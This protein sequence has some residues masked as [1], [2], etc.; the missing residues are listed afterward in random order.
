MVCKTCVDK[1]AEKLIDHHRAQLDLIR[2][3]ELAEKGVIRAERRRSKCPSCSRTFGLKTLLLIDLKRWVFLTNWKATFLWSFKSRRIFWVGKGYN[4]DY[5]LLCTPNGT[6]TCS[7]DG[8]TC[9]LV[10]N[11]C[12]TGSC[13]S[14]LPNSTLTTNSCTASQPLCTFH[15]PYT[16]SGSCIGSGYCYYT[17]TL[18]YKWN[19][20]SCA[21]PSTAAPRGD[22]LVWIVAFLRKKTKPTLRLQN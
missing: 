8:E 2:A 3:Y 22:G 6:A 12:K 21:I 14:P 4:P 17:C 19:G 20:S 5:S 10:T 13:P 15:H 1:L 11:N 7:Y 9:Y 18:P 16:C